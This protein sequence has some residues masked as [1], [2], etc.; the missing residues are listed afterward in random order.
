MDPTVRHPRS[1]GGRR[2]GW[3][4]CF[5]T[6]LLAALV[7][8]PARAAVPEA[9]VKALFLYHFTHFVSWPPAAFTAAQAPLVI[10]LWGSDPFGDTLTRV[11]RDEKAKG[12][13]LE[14]RRVA[15]AAEA[16]S[17]KILYVALGSEA[18][19]RESNLQSSPIL[20][21]GESTAFLRDGGI[22]A[23]RTEAGHIRLRVNLAAAKES[24][25]AIS[26]NLLRL[27]EVTERP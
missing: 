22:I 6:L 19:F 1:V 12:H 13:P 4:R 23:F 3:N 9:T 11:I 10:G 7:L 24:S 27:A 15:N 18:E 5:G 20:T 2:Q 16:K 17:C 25:V 21:V 26:S 14:L 8:A